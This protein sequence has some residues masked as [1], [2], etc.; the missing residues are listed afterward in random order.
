MNFNNYYDASIDNILNELT[1]EDDKGNKDKKDKKDRKDSKDNK[2]STTPY[3]ICR[4]MLNL[5][6]SDFFKCPDNSVTPEEYIRTHRILDIHCKSGNFLIIAFHKFMLSLVNKIP[7]KDKRAEFIWKNLI[8]GICSNSLAANFL[9]IKLYGTNNILGNIYI[10]DSIGDINNLR[11]AEI[12]MD[13]SVI[14][15]NPPYNEDLYLTFVKKAKEWATDYVI[16]ITPAK[17]QTK[18]GIKNEQFREDIVPYMSKIV[19]YP[20]CSDLFKISD[21]GGISYYLIDRIEHYNKYIEN[22]SVKQPALCTKCVR[23]ITNSTLNN[24]GSEIINRIRNSGQYNGSYKIGIISE[25]FKKYSVAINSRFAN[26]R[27]TKGDYQAYG[28]I[29]YKT[30]NA[31]IIRE[32]RII[33]GIPMVGVDINCSTDRIIFTSDN[34]SYCS[35]FYS[36]LNTKFIRYLIFLN[37]GSL[38]ASLEEDTYKFV[39]DPGVFDKIYED[40]PLDGYIP[41]QNGEYID[42]QG[43]K[44]CSL[45]MKYKLTDEEINI[46]EAII[47]E[48]K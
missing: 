27:G 10:G 6:P 32:P 2:K 47:K 4:D 30:H 3:D 29:S 33:E 13:F 31:S 8:Y 21:L 28:L 46:I 48:R 17:W 16:M 41:D 5:L 1:Y 43:N 19:F 24:T 37:I 45:Y 9:R 40:K 38:T 25:Y 39:P 44:H 35:S 23:N 11:K 18:G 36:W 22:K 7:D 12:N 26:E 15:G 14:V 42:K 34:K 20:D